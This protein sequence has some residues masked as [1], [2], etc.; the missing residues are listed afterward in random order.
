M[1][2]LKYTM[3]KEQKTQLGELLATGHRR[4]GM[5]APRKPYR[6]DDDGDSG[7]G[8]AS[9]FEQH[10]LLDE[11]PLGAASDLTNI[12]TENSEAEAEVEKRDAKELSNQ[13]QNQLTN[14]HAHTLGQSHSASPTLTR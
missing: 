10:P 13:M 2:Y 9:P 1:I 6:D 7:I 14:K 8:K 12:A 4:F 5:V 3:N 11:Q